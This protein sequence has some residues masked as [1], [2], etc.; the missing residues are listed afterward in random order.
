MSVVR[1][2]AAPV[3]G[4]FMLASALPALAQAFPSGTVR[5]IVG[6]TPGSAIDIVARI[7]SQKLGELWGQQMLVENRPG[8]GGSVGA[9]I[10]AKAAANGHTLLITGNGFASNPALY[11]N[12]PYDPLKDFTG[13]SLLAAGPFVLVAA[14]ASGL[15]TIS[16]LIALAKSKPGQLNYASAGLG[17]ATHFAAEKF[18]LAAGID[19]VH[20][21]N[22]GGPEANAD[23]IAGRVTYWFAPVASS[24]SLIRDGR[25]IP[26]GVSS[27]RRSSLLPEVPTIAEAGLPGFDET[28]WF[29]L[30]APAATPGGIVDKLARDVGQALSAPDLRERLKNLGAEPANMSPTEFTRFVRAELEGAAR[31]VKAAGIKVE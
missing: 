13:I 4:I 24:I 23:V 12:L 16:D 19:L 17:G 5:V 20:V 8:A 14:P 27:A 22:K 15:K 25:L 1:I 10:V 31:V 29:G 21:P 7:V 26:L 18:R 11:S 6:F 9:G 28:L 2:V 3:L 30:W